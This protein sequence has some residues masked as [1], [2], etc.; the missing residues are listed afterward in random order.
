MGI[1]LLSDHE[2][3]TDWSAWSVCSL[4]MYQILLAASKDTRTCSKDLPVP[5][6]NHA[7]APSTLIFYYIVWDCMGSPESVR[8]LRTSKWEENG[9]KKIAPANIVLFLLVPGGCTS[10]SNC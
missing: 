7:S 9:T 10:Q 5:C 2:Y 8:F 3:C 1:L 4:C 6:E